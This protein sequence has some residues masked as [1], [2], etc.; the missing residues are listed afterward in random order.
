MW[1][2][3]VYSGASSGQVVLRFIFLLLPL[4]LLIISDRLITVTVTVTVMAIFIG[5]QYT[6]NLDGDLMER[7]HDLL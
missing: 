1:P 4:L 3:L 2:Q 5:V 7:A 6:S